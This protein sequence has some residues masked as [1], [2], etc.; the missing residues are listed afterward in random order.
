MFKIQ[1][2]EKRSKW[3]SVAV[4]PTLAESFERAAERHGVTKSDLLRQ[5]I[6]NFLETDLGNS[7]QRLPKNEIKL[8]IFKVS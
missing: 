8:E 6:E 3:I 5:L 4:T 2:P 7:K 1:K